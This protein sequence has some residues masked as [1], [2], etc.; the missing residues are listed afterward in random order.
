MKPG[1]HWGAGYSQQDAGWRIMKPGVHWGAGYSQQ[2]G[3]S[4]ARAAVRQIRVWAAW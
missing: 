3:V 1:V 2:D 4:N